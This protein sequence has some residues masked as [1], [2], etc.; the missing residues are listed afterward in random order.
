MWAELQSASS[1]RVVSSGS[2]VLVDGPLA[3][4]GDSTPDAYLSLQSGQLLRCTRK[5]KRVSPALVRT[6]VLQLVRT[7]LI[8]LV[9]CLAER[10]SSAAIF[11]TF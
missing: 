1:V 7:G 9:W 6:V 11:N 4:W 8:Q 5:K 3:V 10:S 2:W